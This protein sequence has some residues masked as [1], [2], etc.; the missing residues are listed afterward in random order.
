MVIISSE[1][2]DEVK[3]HQ[4]LGDNTGE[5]ASE[6]HWNFIKYEWYFY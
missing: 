5:I 1:L 6:F 2:F 4:E 3:F